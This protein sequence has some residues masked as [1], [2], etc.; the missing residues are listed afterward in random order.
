MKFRW[1][2]AKEIEL[3][4]QWQECGVP[5]KEQARR[6]GRTYLAWKSALL[7]YKLHNEGTY[8]NYDADLRALIMELLPQGYTQADIMRQRK[9]K[10]HS[11]IGRVVRDLIARGLL[12]KKSRTK[13]AAT[14][15]WK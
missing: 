5:G 11:H 1:W 6:L 15:K 7:R 8:T 14:R 2:T 4:R 10:S 9:C 3:V 12:V 13:Y